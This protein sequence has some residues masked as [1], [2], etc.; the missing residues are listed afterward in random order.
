MANPISM[1]MSALGGVFNAMGASTKAA[2][3]QNA[4]RGQMIGTMGKAFQFDVESQNYKW[5][6]G[7]E[8]YQRDV[9]LLNERIAHQNAEYER[10]V[11]EFTAQQLGMKQ[12]WERGQL[13]ASQAAS[14]LSV[15]GGSAV[16]ARAG[17]IDVG[18]QEQAVTRANAAHVAYGYE[19]QAT[20]FEAEA[21]I[22]ST[23]AEMDKLQAENAT[24]AANITRSTLGLQQASM[25]LAKS[26]GTIGVLSSL[27]GAAG[28][29]AGKWMTGGF[30]GMG[31]P[32]S[33]G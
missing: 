19:V 29:V 24:T 10:E 6:S 8:E 7:V 9:A 17:M 28:S 3:E 4:I 11:G 1:G 32:S 21:A 18:Y 27:T 23:T 30:Q 20:Q 22:H 31:T 2:G 15:K 12:Q 25:D 33:S 16:A 13:L 26:A 5:K 14:G